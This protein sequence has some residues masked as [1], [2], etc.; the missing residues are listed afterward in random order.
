MERLWFG[1]AAS[2]DPMESRA[3]RRGHSWLRRF[4]IGRWEVARKASTFRKTDVR[5]AVEAVVA[6]GKEVAC[7]EF[8]K[9]GFKI[10]TGKPDGHTANGCS[11]D[12]ATEK[13][14]SRQ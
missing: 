12:E 8:T 10:I 14:T 11:W 3:C 2:G 13:L 4:S 7:I 5:R 9:D 6:A 1:R